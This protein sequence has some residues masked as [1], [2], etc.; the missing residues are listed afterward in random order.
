[1]AEKEGQLA[2][3][4]SRTLLICF[5][6][7]RGDSN[8]WMTSILQ[9]YNPVSRWLRGR[10]GVSMSA[11]GCTLHYRKKPCNFPFYDFDDDHDARCNV[12]KLIAI[13]APLAMMSLHSSHPMVIGGRRRGQLAS[14]TSAERRRRSCCTLSFLQT[15]WGTLSIL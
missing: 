13:I 10:P 11:R 5:N 2:R 15:C 3:L 1:M 7:L 6:W 9:L 12:G 4:R 14:F 8:N